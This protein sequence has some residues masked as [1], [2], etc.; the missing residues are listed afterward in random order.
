MRQ[1]ALGL[2]VV[3]VSLRGLS[4]V[5]RH[6]RKTT[7]GRSTDG[8]SPAPGTRRMPEART[9]LRATVG[10]IATLLCGALSLW[11]ASASAW[12]AISST[13]DNTYVTNGTLPRDEW[14]RSVNRQYGSCTISGKVRLGDKPTAT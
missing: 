1:I 14:F 9:P 10:I 4:G 7:E 11:F 5:I 2:R 6:G 8:A 13:A 12:A 3:V